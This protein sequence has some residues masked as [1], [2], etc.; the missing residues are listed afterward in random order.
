MF[1]SYT[2]HP[3]RRFKLKDGSSRIVL[4]KWVCFIY[5]TAIENIM[6]NFINM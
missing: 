1:F 4:P 5:E 2:Y 3:L 6:Y